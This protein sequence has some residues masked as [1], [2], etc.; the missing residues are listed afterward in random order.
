MA[1][2]NIKTLNDALKL[3]GVTIEQY[4]A[5]TQGLPADV[6][7]YIALRHV[8]KALNEG[9]EPKFTSEECRWYVWFDCIPDAYLKR[10]PDE[11]PKWPISVRAG[12]NQ[13]YHHAIVRVSKDWTPQNEQQGVMMANYGARLVFK[14]PALA[15]YAG[16]QFSEMFLTFFFGDQRNTKL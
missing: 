7:A 4:Q 11:V 5:Q 13:N 8:C 9:W 10:Y 15:K 6:R 3:N 14:D 16:H 2:E 12:Q 1:A